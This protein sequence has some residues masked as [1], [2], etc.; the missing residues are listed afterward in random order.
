MA[1]PNSFAMSDGYVWVVTNRIFE[2]ASG[3]ILF[4]G[5]GGANF[6]IVR[7]ATPD[8][9]SYSSSC[10]SKLQVPHLLPLLIFF[11]VAHFNWFLQ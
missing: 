8:D 2:F 3:T 6:R 4:P 9:K 5:P 7:S 1:W 10:S 11:L